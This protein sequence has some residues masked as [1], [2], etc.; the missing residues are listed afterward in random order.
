[1]VAADGEPLA[2]ETKNADSLQVAVVCA[3][4]AGLGS[5]VTVTVNGL[6]TQLPVAPEVGVTV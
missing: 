1:M 2:G 3:G 6:P 4:I 5:T